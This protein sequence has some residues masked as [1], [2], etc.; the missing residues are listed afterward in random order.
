MHDQATPA[1]PAATVKER[2]AKAPLFLTVRESAALLRVDDVTVTRAIAAGEF[3]AVKIRRRYVIPSAAIDRI[4]REVV[5]SGRC[6][7]LADW[8]RAWAAETGAPLPAWTR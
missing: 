1:Q 4:I 6:I 7:D 8:T 2:F 5:E 3:P